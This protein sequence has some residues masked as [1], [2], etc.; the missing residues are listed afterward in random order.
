MSKRE[1]M[2]TTIYE[3]LPMTSKK[4]SKTDST[5]FMSTLEKYRNENEENKLL[6]NL[7]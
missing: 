4:I 2:T 7:K 5:G 3:S 1:T 6:A